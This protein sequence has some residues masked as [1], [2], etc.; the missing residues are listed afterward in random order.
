M[1]GTSPKQIAQGANRPITRPQ[2]R[3]KPSQIW[4]VASNFR[5]Q[6]HTLQGV[7]RGMACPVL[8]TCQNGPTR[9]KP[10]DTFERVW[11]PLPWKSALPV[12]D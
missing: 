3:S 1:I 9:L 2:S 7:A 11:N 5:A 8:K 12:V 4:Q 6:M 10:C